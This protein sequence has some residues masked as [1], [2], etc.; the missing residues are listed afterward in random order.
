ML[1]FLTPDSVSVITTKY[2]ILWL[3]DPGDISL[4]LIVYFL[5]SPPRIVLSLRGYIREYLPST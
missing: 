1:E 2:S 5:V 3:R 4:K